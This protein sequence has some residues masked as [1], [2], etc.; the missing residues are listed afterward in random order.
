M[1][2]LLR[3]QRRFCEGFFPYSSRPIEA[4]QLALLLVIWFFA[5]GGGVCFENN[6][7]LSG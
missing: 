3:S 5:A 7:D 4:I 1:L 6:K 2:I